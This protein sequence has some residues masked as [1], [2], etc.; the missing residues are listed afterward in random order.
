MRKGEKLN[1]NDKG[2]KKE[3]KVMVMCE[4]QGRYKRNLRVRNGTNNKNYNSTQLFS[5]WF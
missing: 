5:N 1:R 3:L 4:S 2:N